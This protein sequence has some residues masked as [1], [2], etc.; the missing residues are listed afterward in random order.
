M[1]CLMAIFLFACSAAD[2]RPAQV[3]NLTYEE[4]P[5]VPTSE[6][7]ENEIEEESI[8]YD[9]TEL[10]DLLSTIDTEVCS[11]YVQSGVSGATSF[12]VGTYIE[13]DGWLE[14]K[15]EWF[16]FPNEQW[17]EEGGEP[18]SIEW[19]V[20]VKD[21][22]SDCSDCALRITVESEIAANTCPAFISNRVSDWDAVYSIEKEGRSAI[23]S[24]ESGE[25]FGRGYHVE[26]AMNFATE[27]TCLW[28]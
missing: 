1:R 23:F 15:E 26:R 18:C 3:H 11:S 21:I 13:N 24:Y 22:E 12:F 6:S 8:T 19:N 20:H 14:G 16:I 9:N 17:I 2:M 25:E 5:S 28:F 7:S 4:S 27:T 10:P